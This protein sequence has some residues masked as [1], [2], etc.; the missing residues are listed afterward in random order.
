MYNHQW[1]ERLARLGSWKSNF[2][3]VTITENRLKIEVK[4]YTPSLFEEVLAG[5]HTPEYKN[6][7]TIE[8]RER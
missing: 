7:V 5:K 3:S 8:E 2:S 1:N 4:K 6:D